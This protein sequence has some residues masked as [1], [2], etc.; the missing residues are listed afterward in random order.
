IGGRIL[1]RERNR[2]LVDGD[3]RVGRWR[4]DA[5]RADVDTRNRARNRGTERIGA[6]GRLASHE[7][8]DANDREKNKAVA[9]DDH[10]FVGRAGSA[11]Y[12][13]RTLTVESVAS[14]AHLDAT[15]A[16]TAG[17]RAVLVPGRT[18]E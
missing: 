15:Q 18:L 5:R 7:A 17:N 3:L 1:Y 8:K 2:L 14:V 12:L 6:L 4:H 16:T 13:Y 11:T 10:R 9:H